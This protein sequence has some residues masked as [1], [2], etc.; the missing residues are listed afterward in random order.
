MILTAI[1][2]ANMISDKTYRQKNLILWSFRSLVKREGSKVFLK[3]NV[4]KFLLEFCKLHFYLY[5]Y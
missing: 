4:V 1:K 3:L 5:I 2:K